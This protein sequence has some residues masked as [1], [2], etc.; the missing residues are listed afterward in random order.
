[1]VRTPESRRQMTVFHQPTDPMSEVVVGENGD[2]T[3]PLL[4]GFRLPLSTL[5]AEADLLE[6]AQR[7]EAEE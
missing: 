2:Y 5:L 6:R 1:M 3:T 4:P 7:E